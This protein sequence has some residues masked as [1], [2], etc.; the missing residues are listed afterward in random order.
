MRLTNLNS[1]LMDMADE[2]SN[3]SSEDEKLGFRKAMAIVRNARILN[4]DKLPVVRDLR[5]QVDV[6]ERQLEAFEHVHLKI[7]YNYH[8]Y[9]VAEICKMLDETQE[10]KKQN[11]ALR[12]HV[13]KASDDLK[14]YL[15][16]NTERGVV[17]IPENIVE[18]IVRSKPQQ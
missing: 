7:Q 1:I 16:T 9:S 15:E 10:L 11:S 18:K 5:E 14:F 4:E 12:A 17:Y 13:K 6:F 2:Y 8:E 3:L